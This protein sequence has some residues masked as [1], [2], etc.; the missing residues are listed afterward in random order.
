MPPIRWA[1]AL[2]LGLGCAPDASA[3]CAQ[4]LYLFDTYSGRGILV[5]ER[6]NARIRSLEVVVS[7][8]DPEVRAS[9]FRFK[10]SA[11]RVRPGPDRWTFVVD[12]PVLEV[13]RAV[14][15]PQHDG[16]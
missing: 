3:K 10:G 11:L 15:P 12:L 9:R 2:A 16:L 5:A 4:A 6:C 14:D 13:W 1:L 8:R 7:H